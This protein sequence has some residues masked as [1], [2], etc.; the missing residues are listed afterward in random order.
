MRE[1]RQTNNNKHYNIIIQ[2]YESLKRIYVETISENQLKD[3]V[4]IR[5]RSLIEPK[6]DDY[7]GHQWSST[8]V[9]ILAQFCTQ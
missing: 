7:F 3:K 6:I 9:D 2:S 1:E 5:I 4:E 8:V